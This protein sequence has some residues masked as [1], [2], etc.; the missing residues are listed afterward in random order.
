[1]D[2]KLKTEIL[3][4]AQKQPICQH[5]SYNPKAENPIH[6]RVPIETSELTD[7]LLDKMC[8]EIELPKQCVMCIAFMRFLKLSKEE[9]ERLMQV[10]FE[11]R[12]KQGAAE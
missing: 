6:Q 3:Q 1:M 2:E 8:K 12:K 7:R 9:K 5:C 10:E 4:E 11:W